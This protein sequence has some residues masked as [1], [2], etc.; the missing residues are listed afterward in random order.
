[1]VNFTQ[2]KKLSA[3]LFLLTALF[4]PCVVEK[5][6]QADA[7]N[8]DGVSILPKEGACTSLRTFT[9]TF[10]KA[11]TFTNTISGTPD[12]PYLTLNGTRIGSVGSLS[13][14]NVKG[15]TVTYS[16][17]NKEE[18][19]LEAAGT[20]QFIVPAA[21][22]KLDGKPG[23]DLV[24]NY[25]ISASDATLE[26]TI[27][28]AEGDV[29]G[30]D[31]IT[32]SFNK[33]TK[34]EI[35]EG[36]SNAT[37]L[38]NGSSDVAITTEVFGSNKYLIKVADNAADADGTYTLTIPAG[39]LNVD[40]LE[41]KEIKVVYNVKHVVGENETID[42]VEGSYSA[43]SAFTVTFVNATDVATVKNA[44][45]PYLLASGGNTTT[46]KNVT[47]KESNK[48]YMPLS[49]ELTTEGSYTLVIPAGSY[50]VDGENGTELR[51]EYT[52]SSDASG[53]GSISADGSEGMD[54][55]SISGV[56]IAEK[57]S[58][59]SVSGLAKGIYVING[60]KYIVR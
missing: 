33:A 42:P 7:A 4:A 26:R 22:Y 2:L 6:S 40:G 50:T 54:V 60:K 21:A 51:F 58:T 19:P 35:A 37:T 5:T 8:P 13:D 9:I 1:M 16:I 59:L 55:Y 45:K 38:K 18:K 52:I 41:N 27:D 43:L 48:L 23:T 36:K 47:A 57:A 56:K 28:P 11:T 20:Y 29:D 24:F 30:L 39:T 53:I 12:C 15:N 34:V 49:S 17:T 14:I 10:E 31:G 44:A 3:G 46:V 32:V 25:T